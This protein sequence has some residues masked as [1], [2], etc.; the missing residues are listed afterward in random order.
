MS[1]P[2]DNRFFHHI[3]QAWYK[4][5]GSFEQVNWSYI[6]EDP[7]DGQTVNFILKPPKQLNQELMLKKPIWNTIE[8]TLLYY[9]LLFYSTV[10]HLWIWHEVYFQKYVT[11]VNFVLPCSMFTIS[12][13]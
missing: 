12:Q 4:S 6:Q 7:S 1:T 3:N 8:T 5:P 13:S 11:M 2:I 9:S 10:G